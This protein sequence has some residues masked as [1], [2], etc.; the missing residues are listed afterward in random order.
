M[1]AANEKKYE[2]SL[3]KAV[4]KLG[5]EC[6]KFHS[7]YSTGWPDRSILLPGGLYYPCEIKSDG[8]DLSE[9]QK[10]RVRKLLRLGFIPLIVN[11][12]E[13]LTQ[14]IDFLKDAVKR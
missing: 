13:T 14:T 12:K 4:Q 3:R 9:L 5:G 6:L 8:V 2:E 11:S 7:P 10:A 1:A